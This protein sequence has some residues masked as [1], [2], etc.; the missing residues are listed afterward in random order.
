VNSRQSWV[1]GAYVA[2]GFVRDLFLY[3][4]NED[5]DIVIERDGIEFSRKY[6]KKGGA[7]GFIPTVNCGTAVIIFPDG[8]KIDVCIRPKGI[9]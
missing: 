9:L 2:G 7:P 3:R 4:P 8:F 5:I 6:A 1:L